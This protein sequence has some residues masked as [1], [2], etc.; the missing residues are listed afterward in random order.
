[1]GCDIHI[2]TE[3]KKN[4]KWVAADPWVSNPN[5]VNALFLPFNR[6]ICKGKRNYNTF[7]ILSDIDR[8]SG[9]LPRRMPI[10]RSLPIDLSSAIKQEIRRWLPDGHHYNWLTLEELKS[11]NWDYTIQEHFIITQLVYL[12]NVRDGICLP[13][14]TIPEYIHNTQPLGKSVSLTELGCI[15]DKFIQET[16]NLSKEEYEIQK[17]LGTIPYDEVIQLARPSSNVPY[18][19]HTCDVPLKWY[20]KEFVEEDMV[21]LDQLAQQPDVEDVR[22]IFWFDN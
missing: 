15:V 4:G 22:I 12:L 6:E 9:P 10:K 8:W 18:A 19:I 11:F 1:M 20:C 14:N 3:V 21:A 13:G 5:Y 16:L 7:K 17:S 2:F